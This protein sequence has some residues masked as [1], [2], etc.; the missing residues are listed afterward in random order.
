MIVSLASMMT[1]HNTTLMAKVELS[2]K[3]TTLF[4]G[5]IITLVIYARGGLYQTYNFLNSVFI[6][7]AGLT[8]VVTI[9]YL[10]EILRQREYSKFR[11]IRF[12]ILLLLSILSSYGLFFLLSLKINFLDALLLFLQTFIFSA[13]IHALS[14]KISLD[15]HGI[16]L[17]SLTGTCSVNWDGISSVRWVDKGTIALLATKYPKEIFIPLFTFAHQKEILHYFQTHLSKE[18]TNIDFFLRELKKN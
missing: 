5:L 6:N 8:I 17:R 15:K 14:S 12:R 13:F 2:W 4:I 16:K 18:N 3:L 11:S 7:I 9:I 1:V 10:L